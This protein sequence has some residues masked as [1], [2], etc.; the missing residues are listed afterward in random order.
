MEQADRATCE[1]RYENIELA[2]PVTRQLPEANSAGSSPFAILNPPF[3]LPGPRPRHRLHVPRQKNRQ[4]N[5]NKPLASP[6]I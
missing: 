6:K 2:V 1:F 3:A 5:P 4:A